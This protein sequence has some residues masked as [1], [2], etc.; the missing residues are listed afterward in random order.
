MT[1]V[2]LDRRRLRDA[3]ETLQS[4][5]DAFKDAAKTNDSLEEAIGNPHGKDK[6][7]D[8]IGWFE[9]NWS[10]NREELREM[11]DGILEGLGSIVDGWDEWEREAAA[12]LES[13][14]S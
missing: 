6:L 1:D 10:G 12:S 5:S 2:L 8:R 14:E 4:A 3:R 11:I 7:R 9:A 13:S